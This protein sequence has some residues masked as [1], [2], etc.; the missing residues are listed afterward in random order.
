M[1]F[2]FVYKF[3]AAQLRNAE[4]RKNTWK[5]I[6]TLHFNYETSN[7]FTRHRNRLGKWLPDHR[8]QRIYLERTTNS[9]V[10]WDHSIE[11]SWNWC[12]MIY[13]CCGQRQK[14][15]KI[16]PNRMLWI[17]YQWLALG[18]YRSRQCRIQPAWI[19]EAKNVDRIRFQ[20]VAINMH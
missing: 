14:I 10:I 1:G 9:L 4:L 16:D 6:F 15:C 12:L 19:A 13:N 2:S 5:R 20:M 7:A 18:S 3:K 11:L 8:L 17:N